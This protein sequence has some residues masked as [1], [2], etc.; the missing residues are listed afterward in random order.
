MAEAGALAL[1]EALAPGESEAVA[2][3]VAVAGALALAD[4]LA[5]RDSEAVSEGVG[6]AGA[7][8]V[9]ETE[10][11]RDSEAVAAAVGEEDCAVADGVAAG[12]DEALAPRERVAVAA[13]EGLAEDERRVA[14]LMVPVVAAAT[15]ASCEKVEVGGDAVARA[16]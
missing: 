5:P 14:T 10:A 4:A 11:P 12:V 2:V 9:A 16:R 1:T 15:P 3:A 8:E 13:G 6:V 7:L